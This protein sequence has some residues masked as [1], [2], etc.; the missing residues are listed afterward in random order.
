MLLTALIQMV[1]QKELIIRLKLLNEM[2]MVSVTLRILEIE[3]C[4]QRLS[5]IKET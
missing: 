4:Y 2:V 5:Y 3:F 1:L